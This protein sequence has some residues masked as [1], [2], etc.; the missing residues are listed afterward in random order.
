M[1]E[2]YEV[3]AHRIII[4]WGSKVFQDTLQ[5]TKHVHPIIYLQG[6]SRYELKSQNRMF[7]RVVCH[8]HTNKN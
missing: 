1:C 8:T 5:K 3:Q 2:D 7:L 6:I 4:S